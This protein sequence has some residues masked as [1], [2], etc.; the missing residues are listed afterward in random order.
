MSKYWDNIDIS[1][2]AE[3]YLRIEVTIPKFQICFN[4]TQAKI[5]KYFMEILLQNYII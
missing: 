1:D 2:I 4:Y 3:F 5:Q